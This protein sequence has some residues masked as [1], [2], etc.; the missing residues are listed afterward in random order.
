MFLRK[1]TLR[2]HVENVHG[3]TTSSSQQQ[4][5]EQQQ[6]QQDI[7]QRVQTKKDITSTTKPTFTASLPVLTRGIRFIFPSSL[8]P[9]CSSTYSSQQREQQQQQ[10]QQQQ[11]FSQD[12]QIKKDNTSN[13]S[14]TLTSLPPVL[15]RG[16]TFIFPSSLSSIFILPS[17]LSNSSHAK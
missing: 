14:S 13:T 12:I 15:T 7:S 1:S 10:Q 6:E 5:Q 2:K 17:T 9:H 3:S 8:S 4:E 16:I 11:G